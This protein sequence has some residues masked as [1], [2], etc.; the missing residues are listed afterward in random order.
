MGCPITDG[1]LSSSRMARRRLFSKDRFMG[2][3][4]SRI[5]RELRPPTAVTLADLLALVVGVAII[6]TIPWYYWLHPFDFRGPWPRWLPYLWATRQLVA[7]ACLALVPAIITRRAIFGGLVR[8]AEF[9][10]C[11]GGLPQLVFGIESLLMMSWLRLRHGIVI[12]TIRDETPVSFG[13]EWRQGPYWTWKHG[14]LIV[15]VLAAVAFLLGRR[16]LPGWLLTVLLML[17][18]AGFQATVAEQVI[19]GIGYSIIAIHGRPVD[20]VVNILIRHSSDVLLGFLFYAVPALVALYDFRRSAPRW[21]WLEW[22]GLGLSATLLLVSETAEAI[23]LHAIYRGGGY[24]LEEAM[25]RAV[26]MLVA[27]ALG[28]FI[29]RRLGPAWSRQ[30]EPGYADC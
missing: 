3:E 23:R 15:A 28:F 20:V 26:T 1:L 29:A 9:L 4:S 22:T 11:A 27:I 24:W 16:R 13:K 8:P 2:N 10:A 25:P 17:A 12:F 14:L 7:M 21:S 6:A 5:A 18:W 19:S 30:S